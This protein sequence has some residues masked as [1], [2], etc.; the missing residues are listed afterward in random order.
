ML[1][2]QAVPDRLREVLQN[3]VEDEERE[4]RRLL[5]SRR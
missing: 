3:L 2:R 1:I 5:K 4:E